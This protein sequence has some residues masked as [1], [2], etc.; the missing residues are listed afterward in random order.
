MAF[1]TKVGHAASSAKT[2][3]FLASTAGADSP[4]ASREKPREGIAREGIASIYARSESGVRNVR[5]ETRLRGPEVLK[6]P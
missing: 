2:V 6:P 5:R 3:F 4:D 1:P